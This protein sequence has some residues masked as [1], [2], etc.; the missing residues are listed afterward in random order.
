M[1]N[2][3]ITISSLI[4]ISINSFTWFLYADNLDMS[5]TYQ[6]EMKELDDI[7]NSLDSSSDSLTWIIDNF[8]NKPINNS[9]TKVWTGQLSTGSSN[10]STNKKAWVIDRFRD[11]EK[12]IVDS[13][14]ENTSFTALLDV[15]DAKSQLDTLSKQYTDVTNEYN[16]IKSRKTLLDKKYDEVKQSIVSIMD[17][18]NETKAQISDRIW[19]IKYYT[20]A[21]YELKQ[22]LDIV[23]ADIDESKTILVKYT[24]LLYKINNDFYGKDLNIDDIKLLVKSDNI[25]DSLSTEDVV[26]SLTV[27]LDDLLAIL[28]EKQEKYTLYTKQL[29]DLRVKYKY[30]V[31]QYRRDIDNFNE[32]KKYLVELFNYLR[33]TK[34]DLD[35]K[36][37]M[38]NNNKE[39][40]QKEI[41]NALS[42][43]KN[44]ISEIKSWWFDIT[45]LLREEEREDSDRFFSLPVLPVRKITAFFHDENYIKHLGTDHLAVD[46]ASPQWSE[47]YAPANWV[48]YKVFDKDTPDVNRL[49]VVHKNWY[50]TI[51]IHMYKIFVK[52]WD[53]IKRWQII[54]LS[55]G[56]P[57]T[58]GAWFLS[59]WPHLH[60]NVIKNWENIDPLTVM[61]LSAIQSI[62]V[63][64]EQY[65]YK[66]L[67]DRYSR[68]IDLTGV[69]F[70]KWM[71]TEERRIAFLQKFARGPFTDIALWEDAAEWTNVDLDLGICI[72]YAESG[73]GWHLASNRNI[74]NV[75]NNDRW[76]RVWFDWAFDWVRSIFTTL[77]NPYL[78]KHYTLDQLSRF[79]NK[80]WSIY[81]SS[82]FN[83]EKNIVKCLS[84]IKWYW[85]PEDYP[86]RKYIWE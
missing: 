59:T 4:A 1:F 67:R 83:W 72:W 70:V 24:N 30:E 22:N 78:W 63:L 69:K 21:L 36:F 41:M 17:N 76:D 5:G 15:E 12:E 84:V 61:D 57:W 71:T 10:T 27:K 53:F 31:K 20:K 45:Q 42:I 77:S 58:R 35:S 46:I 18:I 43:S 8:D 26:K 28:S 47:V 6:A 82:D 52:D 48:V 9:E 80:K 64:P 11:R 32:Q 74:G 55:G 65:H 54:G 73:L 2:K 29:N 86:I 37:E 33:W 68:K 44:K 62:D 56:Q 23:K 39:Y 51:Y 66:Y 19:K 40:L 13:I 38:L 85:V 7:S 49:I 34:S 3:I 79:W 25:A 81:A 16:E 14:Y 50:V 75:W 60:F